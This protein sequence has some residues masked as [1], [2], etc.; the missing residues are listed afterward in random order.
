MCGQSGLDHNV[1]WACA[2][3]S[4]T[5]LVEV[6]KQGYARI[7]PATPPRLFCI[8]LVPKQGYVRIASAGESY[9]DTYSGKIGIM[10]LEKNCPV[11]RKWLDGGRKPKTDGDS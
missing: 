6:P 7:T 11:Y 1:I 5:E 9:L 3:L 4:K 2:R 10:E 8:E